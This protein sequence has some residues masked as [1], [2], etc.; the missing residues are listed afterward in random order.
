M[1]YNASDWEG[2]ECYEDKDTN[3]A[4]YRGK[5]A[6][7]KDGDACLSW[8]VKVKPNGGAV[9]LWTGSS[10]AASKGLGEHNYCRNPDNEDSPWCY[11]AKSDTAPRFG[12]CTV[13]AAKAADF[14][15]GTS[16]HACVMHAAALVATDSG[17]ASCPH[18]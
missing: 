18:V 9:G 17:V 13:Q 14:C 15:K 8:T 2:A 4:D 10:K 7:T 11:T 3:G 5:V 1:W 6:A 12:L 16:V